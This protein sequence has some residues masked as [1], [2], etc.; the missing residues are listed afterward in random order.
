MENIA[1]LRARHAASLDSAKRATNEP[2]RRAHA[3]M[4]S[5]YRAQIVAAEHDAEP[6]RRTRSR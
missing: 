1:Y 3:Q 2:A 4:A 6:S 5:L